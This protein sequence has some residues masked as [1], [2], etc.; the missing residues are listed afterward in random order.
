[1]YFGR[2]HYVMVFQQR[3]W[4][5]ASANSFVRLGDVIE[6]EEARAVGVNE[7]NSRLDR[8]DRLF[9]RIYN[10]TVERLMNGTQWR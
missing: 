1:M 6:R 2:V 10:C 8:Q 3:C 9:K 4:E 7:T 5:N